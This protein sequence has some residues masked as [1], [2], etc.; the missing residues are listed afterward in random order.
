MR[1]VCVVQVVLMLVT[2][3][4]TCAIG[5]GLWE[6]MVGFKFQAYLPWEEFVPG[7][8]LVASNATVFHVSGPLVLALLNYVAYI[9]MLSSLIPISLYVRYF[10]FFIVVPCVS[11]SCYDT[12]C[13]CCLFSDCVYDELCAH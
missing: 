13:V 2:I 5:C 11:H 7:S 3:S 8:V 12:H 6:A 9:I 4:A 10:T 1:Y